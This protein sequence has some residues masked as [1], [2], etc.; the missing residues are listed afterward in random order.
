[1]GRELP[2]AFEALLYHPDTKRI[3]D[4]PMVNYIGG[5]RVLFRELEKHVTSPAELKGYMTLQEAKL[6]D[7]SLDVVEK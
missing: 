3:N 7:A 2:R 1:M 4:E 6:N 5:K